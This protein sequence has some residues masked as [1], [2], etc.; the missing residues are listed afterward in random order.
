MR[1]LLRQSRGGGMVFL[2]EIRN[3]FWLPVRP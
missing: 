1:A 3:A 2:D